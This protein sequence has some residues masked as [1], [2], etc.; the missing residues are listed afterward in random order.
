MKYFAIIKR[1]YEADFGG[2]VKNLQDNGFMERVTWSD[3]K[4][5]KCPSSNDLRLFGLWKNGVSGSVSGLF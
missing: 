2:V 5:I 3:G 4:T 1:N